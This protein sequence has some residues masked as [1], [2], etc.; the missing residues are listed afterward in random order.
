MGWLDE[1]DFVIPLAH[2]DT[3]GDKKTQMK[4]SWDK[5]F[6]FDYIVWPD[7]KTHTKRRTVPHDNSWLIWWINSLS[8]HE[9]IVWLSWS[10]CLI[11]RN[12]WKLKLSYN[13]DSQRIYQLIKQ[14]ACIMVV[15]L[16][17]NHFVIGLLYLLK[18]SCW[19]PDQSTQLGLNVELNYLSWMLLVI[20]KWL[21]SSWNLMVYWRIA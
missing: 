11:C 8:I 2:C 5:I 14:P 13:E 18:G 3:S 9:P 1:L 17:W 21:H 19:V 7:W 15:M 6:S 20:L 4:P 16:Y 10:Q 12:S